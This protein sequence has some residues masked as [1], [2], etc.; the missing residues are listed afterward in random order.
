MGPNRTP[1]ATSVPVSTN[2]SRKQPYIN[3]AAE[4]PCFFCNSFDQQLHITEPTYSITLYHNL[5]R[6]QIMITRVQKQNM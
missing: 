6:I 4:E 3:T 1:F 5:S 2:L